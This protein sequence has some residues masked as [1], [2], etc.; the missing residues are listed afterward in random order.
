MTPS[1]WMPDSWANAL[2]P[3]IALFGWIAKPGQVADE[4]AGGG[5]LLGRRR[6]SRASGNCVGRVRRAITTSSSDALPARSPRP[7]I[8]TSTWRAPAW[9][10]AS[11]LAVARPRSLW[12]WTLTVAWSPTRSTTRLTS[13]AELGR[14]GVA[15]GVGDVDRG[16]A[17]LDDRLVDLEQVVEVGARGVLGAELDLGVAAEL[18]A[19]VADPADGLGQ[20]GLAIDPELVLEVDVARRDEDVE[21]R[22]L[23][24]LDRLDGAL[25]VAVLAARER[26]DRDAR[27]GSPGRSGGRPR[28][29]PARRPGSRPR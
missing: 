23:G 5:D 2:P 16:R 13:V 9:T 22:P 12:Q 8:V 20:R 10:A 25:R 15:D 19:A 14:D 1:W 21:V 17:G 24:D 3:T 7:L 26:R 27:R 18:L 6:P 29:R 28:S 11:V 4:A